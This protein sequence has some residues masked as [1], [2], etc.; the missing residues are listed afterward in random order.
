MGNDHYTLLGV[1][2]FA[3]GQEIRQ[4]YREMS[5][6]YHPD[7]T[8]LPPEIATQ[9][10][11]QLNEAYG[12]LSNADRKTAYD[13]KMGYSRVTVVQPLPSLNRPQPRY[14]DSAYLDAHDRPLSAGELFAL[15]ILGVTFVGCL[16]LAITIGLTRGDTILQ[17]TAA[18]E[19][20]IQEDV[21][22]SDS[23]A[24]PMP[25]PNQEWF[26]PKMPEIPDHVAPS[27]RSNPT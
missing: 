2:P 15:F 23:I 22:P 27:V 11:Q 7:T 10:F 14:T 16:V 26:P 3:S 25:L 18:Q 8:Q 20:A 17:P 1:R 9:K 6:L 21:A 19:A 24:E 5:K 13:L 4:A 12:T